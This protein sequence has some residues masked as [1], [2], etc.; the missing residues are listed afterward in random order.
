MGRTCLLCEMP[1]SKHTVFSAANAHLCNW[2]KDSLARKGQAWCSRGR[3]VVPAATMKPRPAW[4][5]QCSHAA[6]AARYQRNIEQERERAKRR[7]QADPQASAARVMAW[8]KANPER[9]RAHRTAWRRRWRARNPE[10]DRAYAAA[11]RSRHRERYNAASRVRK[12]RAKLRAFQRLFRGAP[13][14]R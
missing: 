9:R 7:Y 6:R 14:A 13:R 1:P 3:H 11:W 2:C 12:Q 10:R 5:E 8:E 4:C